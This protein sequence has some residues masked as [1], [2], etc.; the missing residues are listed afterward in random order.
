MTRV[1]IAPDKF[2]GSLTASVV[3]S[4]LA[5]G[6]RSVR[7]DLTITQLPVADGG[8]GTVDAAVA[9]GF[10]RVTLTVT[11]P[12]G[13]PVQ[14]SYARR[15]DEAVVELADVC[16]L[17]RLPGGVLAPSTADTRGL[18]EVLAATLEAG[19]T[20]IVLG[21]G[22]SAGT[23]GG[24]G[25]RSALGVGLLTAGGEPIPPGGAGLA[26]V[27]RIDLSGLHPQVRTARI[28]LACDVDNP[29]TGPSGAAAVYGPQKGASPAEVE[30]LD[31]TLSRW[32]DLVAAA[33]GADGRNTPGAGAAGGVGF[34]AMSVLGADPAPGISTMF[35][36]VGFTGQLAGAD[37]VITGEGSLDDQTLNGKAP[38]GVATATTAAGI[39]VIAV[40]G[41]TLL[42][43]TSWRAAGFS[44]V[45]PLT[46]LEPDPARSMRDAESLLRQV[47]R[48][49]ASNWL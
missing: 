20:S 32:A 30:V 31:A 44:Q 13:A 17:V 26:R 47:G 28:R 40:C 36:I 41:R 45:Y 38:A 2:K 14:T 34:A 16:G 29:L 35:E 37:L 25:M 1:L 42:A 8:D 18:G 12:T 24:A 19:C 49:V 10:E 39:P 46:D 21:V 3:A 15:G 9:A 23:D 48:R 6:M 7:N 11:G 43:E 4:A 22:G 5:D 27:D 33:V